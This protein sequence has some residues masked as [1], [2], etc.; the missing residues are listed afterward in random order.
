MDEILQFGIDSIRNTLSPLSVLASIVCS[1]FLAWIITIIYLKNYRGYGQP[2]QMCFSI[3]ICAVVTCAIIMIIGSNIALSLG[4]V[5]ALSIVRFRTPIKD[6]RDLAFLFWSICIGLGCGAD[7][8][9]I[10]SILTIVLGLIVLFIEG[11]NSWSGRYSEYLL[12]ISV[13]SDEKNN[14]IISQLPKGSRFKS[15]TKNENLHEFTYSI[16]EV[17]EGIE[18]VLLKIKKNKFVKNVHVVS[19]DYEV[20]G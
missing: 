7:A 14:E 11:N 5:G 8:Y 15:M 20:L 17:K 10:V 1:A 13:T 3:M 19:P 4:L 16:P 9:V 6:S 12:I 2:Y 18:N